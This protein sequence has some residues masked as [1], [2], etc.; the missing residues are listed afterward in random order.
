LGFYANSYSFLYRTKSID[1]FDIGNYNTVIPLSNNKTDPLKKGS[2]KKANW[3]SLVVQLFRKNITLLIIV[4]KL[5]FV[6]RKGGYFFKKISKGRRKTML[7]NL[8]FEKHDQAMTDRKILSIP[9]L[10]RANGCSEKFISDIESTFD[11]KDEKPRKQLYIIELST[12]L[13]KIGISANIDKR[14]KTIEKSSGSKILNKQ[15]FSV[16][17]PFSTESTLHKTFAKYRTNGEFFKC[18]FINAVD[19]AKCLIGDEADE[20]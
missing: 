2:F 15:I 18:D 17:N 20:T 16:S 10:F 12:G 7:D 13:V 4:A 3:R 5:D 8:V 19:A 14:L 9:D 1:K 6:N 11:S